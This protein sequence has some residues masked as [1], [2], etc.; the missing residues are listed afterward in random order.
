M[1]RTLTAKH[2]ALSTYE[3]ELLAIVMATQKW[4]GYLQGHHFKIKTDHQSL[5]FLLELRLSTLFQQKWLAKLMGLDYEICYKKGKENLVANAL[6]RMYEST[7]EE[8]ELKE[9]TVIPPHWLQDINKSY[10]GDNEAQIIIQGI[11][12][13]DDKYQ[14]YQ[15]N[16]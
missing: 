13:Q 6:S 11:I 16:K 5:K 12:H 2:Q 9:I 3:K 15:F 1:S 4:H 7:R 14:Q 8:G 10:S